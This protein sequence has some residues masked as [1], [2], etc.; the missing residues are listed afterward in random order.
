VTF[1]LRRV[2]PFQFQQDK[3]ASR[4]GEIDI[5]VP[6]VTK[7]IGQAIFS[8]VE[9]PL[10]FLSNARMSQQ[11]VSARVWAIQNQSVQIPPSLTGYSSKHQLG[12]LDLEH[13]IHA[14]SGSPDTG[15]C[16]RSAQRQYK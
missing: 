9:G 14:A 5:A 2:P 10:V 15:P 16:C 12:C 8:D 1:D 4:A 6:S 3:W 11:S 13:Q 7:G